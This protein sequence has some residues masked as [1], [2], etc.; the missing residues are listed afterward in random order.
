M[1][2]VCADSQDEL[3]HFAFCLA[4]VALER[5]KSHGKVSAAR[6][7]EADLVEAKKRD[8]DTWDRYGVSE[9]VPNRGQTV[10]TTR[11]LN[12]EKVLDATTV[13]PKSHLVA[14][15]F[16]AAYMDSLETASP[17]VDRGVWPVMV[18]TTAVNGW[19]P[20]CF[21]MS[22]VFL[23]GRPMTVMSVFIL[24][25]KLMRLT[26]LSNCKTEFM[27]WWLRRCNGM[28]L[29]MRALWR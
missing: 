17:T 16:Q 19:V 22:T 14:R 3:V 27:V 29:S 23:Q 7:A 1:S 10:F 11:L 5:K 8:L 21:D 2:T 24:Q 4:N 13:T 18:A 15:G 6:A 25:Q 26:W 20:Y 28:K 9:L 12:T